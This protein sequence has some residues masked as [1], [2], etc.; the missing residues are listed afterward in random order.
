M[1]FGLSED[2]ILLKQSLR[3]FL[4]EQCPTSRVR[5]V[6]GSDGG[7]DPALWQGLA[8]LGVTGLIVP[9]SYGGSG[10]ELL[11]L[12]LVAEELGYAAAP[13]PFLGNAM[14][15]VALIEGGSPAEQARWLPKIAAG[16]VILTVAYGEEESQWEPARFSA[17]ASGGKI[18]GAKPLVPY[19][20][21]AHAMVVAACDEEGPGLWL[22]EAGAPGI[23]TTPLRVVDQTRRL[24]SVSL[25]DTPAIRLP[26]GAAALRRSLDAGAV[27]I[28][29]D[30][31]G[32]SKR[33]LD[34]TV[35]YV[36]EREQFGQVIGA[37]QAVKHQIANLAS[38]LELALSLT[39][40]AAHAFDHIRDQSERHA[41]MAKALLADTFDRVTRDCTELH[42]G[43]GFTWEYD[44][45]LWFRRA[46]FDRSFLG[47]ASFHRARA[48]DLA[49]W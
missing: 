38:E 39:W 20:R 11:D 5:A 3:R 9:S 37:F 40:Y 17:R 22:V 48:A 10:L 47:E 30:A 18:S 41:A 1:N 36:L 32:G 31:F 43:V 14:A 24:H 42:G 49:G 19:A 35:K 16:E 45:H 4:D 2:Q 13:G 46:I 29:A 25:R 6:M 23:E 44:L 26:D 21:E 28:A 27:L 33:C 34:M 12:A 7:H 15:T 8:D